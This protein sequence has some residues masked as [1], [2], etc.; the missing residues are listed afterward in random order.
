MCFITIGGY[1]YPNTARYWTYLT[2][3]LVNQALSNDIPEH[4][5]Y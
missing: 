4:K 3:L 2:S 5:V 1:N